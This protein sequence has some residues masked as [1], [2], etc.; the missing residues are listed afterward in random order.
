MTGIAT[1]PGLKILPDADFLRV[2]RQT[3]DTMEEKEKTAAEDLV[4]ELERRSGE[5]MA[6]AEETA[7]SMGEYYN[8]IAA[9][10]TEDGQVEASV[11]ALKVTAKTLGRASLR[12]GEL[13]DELDARWHD[14][15][16]SRKQRKVLPAAPANGA[17][18][19]TEERGEHFARG[20][21]IYKLL[22]IFFI[23]SFAGVV[24]ETLWCLVRHGYL[25]SRA[26]LVYGPFNLLYGAGAAALSLCLYRY[27]NRGNWLSFLGG[28]VVGSA[29]EYVCSWGQE[30]LFGSRSW[31][32][33][34]VPFNLNGRI[35]LLY[36]IFWGILGVL[37]IKELYPRMVK[38]ILKIPNKAGKILTWVLAAF[39]VVNAVVSLIAVYRWS[40]RV[41]GVAAANGFWE[42]ID[43]RFPNARMERIY[44]NMKFGQ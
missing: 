25:E 33:S 19:L 1:G 22:W 41:D 27:R 44:A 34:N 24:V 30:V 23:G 36:S 43:A 29:V 2:G 16:R 10:E 20:L 31:D 21:N 7:A 42:F 4:L 13:Y 9:H 40:Q 32:Y 15:R 37:W 14:Q 5:L 3:E 6:L 8:R 26:G 18:D 28:M 11:N 17:I 39:F 12:A 35:C 38:W